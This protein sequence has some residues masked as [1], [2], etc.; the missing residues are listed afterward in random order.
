MTALSIRFFLSDNENDNIADDGDN[1]SD[2]AGFHDDDNDED[3]AASI[4]D[5]GIKGQL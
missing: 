2:N 4:D 3:T 1:A 5:V